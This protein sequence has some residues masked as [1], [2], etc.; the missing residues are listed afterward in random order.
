M[1]R[2][3]RERQRQFLVRT[4]SPC[5][6]FTGFKGELEEKFLP[7]CFPITHT[8]PVGLGSQHFEIMTLVPDCHEPV[9]EE[10]RCQRRAQR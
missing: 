10:R 6:G 3:L 7:I 9:T 8:A 1:D 4:R 2:S 5:V